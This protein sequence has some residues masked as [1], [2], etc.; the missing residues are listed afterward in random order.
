M[1]SH[2]IALLVKNPSD[3]ISGYVTVKLFF[4]S[5]ILRSR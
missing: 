3:N 1:V 4:G 2:R 5:F